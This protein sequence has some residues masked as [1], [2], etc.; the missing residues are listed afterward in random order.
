MAEN[1]HTPSHVR[2]SRKILLQNFLADER[3]WVVAYSGGKDSTLVLQLVFEMLCGLPSEKLKPVHIISSDT[4]VE[5]PNI[6]RYM[7]S[8]LQRLEEDARRRHLNLSTHLVKPMAE[9]AFWGNLIGKG[10]PP[11]TRWFRWC[12]T[13]MKI[14][15]S[16]KVIEKITI[17]SGSVILLLGTRIDESHQRGQG[18][19]SRESNNRGLNPHHQIPNALVLAPISDWSNDQVWEYL[20]TNNPPWGGSHDEMMELYRQANSG[21]CP[22][23]MDLNT[24]S[25]GGSRFGCWT[26]TVV[27]TDKSM[28]SFIDNGEEWMLPLN[29]FRNWL[30]EIREEENRRC[31]IRRN[32]E[33]GLGPFDSATRLE[34]LEELFKTEQEVGMELISDEELIYIQQIWTKEF[35]VM[36]SALRLASRFSR[37]PMRK[38]IIAA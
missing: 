17:G 37:F 32:G 26:C 25:C 4:G 6:A 35:D 33:K 28:E 5:P 20:F 36:R 10:Y 1:Q 13:K 7:H 21:E 27:K 38:E 23:V 2:D 9:N 12:T 16:R 11:P 19:K 8:S 34:M 18:M 3:P 30:K 14:N 22:L 15:P 29:R 31:R 24:P